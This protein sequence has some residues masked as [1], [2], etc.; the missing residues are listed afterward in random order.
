MKVSI[1]VP[2][3]N[4][5]EYLNKCLDSI[6]EQTFKKLE[7][8]LVNDGSTDNSI[9][10]I[11]E[12]AKKD[13]RIIIIDKENEGV[14]IARNTGIKRSTGEYITFVDSDDYLEK[15]A[16][17]KM[18]NIVTSKNV[19]IVR[20]NYQ[21]HY[22]NTN[23]VD[24]GN[25]FGYENKV[26]NSK[27]IK[28]D[29]IPL[30]LSGK[31][32]CFIY[33]LMIKRELLFKTKLFPLNIH[34]MEDVVLYIDL[35]TKSSNIYILGNVTYNINF[36]ELGA[37]NNK[38]NYE[39]NVFNILDVNSYLKEIL[40]REKLLNK[41]NILLLNNSNSEAITDFIFKQYLYGDNS[42]ELCKKLSN[43]NV[44]NDII[45]NID[46]KKINI[47]RRIIVKLIKKRKFKTLKIYFKFRKFLRKL[48]G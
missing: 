33:L 46:K 44:M 31:I 17:E 19:D 32:P 28:N 18:Y 10:I 2:V 29:I 21:V 38:K 7:I 47:Q 1:I 40:K 24:V 15:D 14:S 5:S 41:E 26:Y 43:D 20:S 48:K 34:M 37:T 13:K 25:L 6:I 22:N 39:R 8:I 35:F 9:D 36:N 11:N 45:N 42:I 12:Y 4:A 27:E 23:K 16:I 30:L 3:Y